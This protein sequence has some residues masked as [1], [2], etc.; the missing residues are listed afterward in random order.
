[1]RDTELYQHLLGLLTP[2]T[3]N[4]VELKPNEQRVDVWTEHAEG[5]K[6][7]C[8]VLGVEL[9]GCDH[10]PE[11]SGRPLDSCQFTTY[12]RAVTLSAEQREQVEADIRD[13]YHRSR[14]WAEK[15]WRRRYLRATRS[16]LEPVI[17]AALTVHRHIGNLLTQFKHRITSAVSEE[18]DSK[19]QMIKKRAYGFHDPESFK[20]AVHLHL[21]GLGLY[22]ASVD[23]SATH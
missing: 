5:T 21:G 7:P 1:M 14:S 9:P 4:R 16:R 6:W 12:L 8:P 10:A 2:W 17:T 11:R 19:I 18:L 15:H 13:P 3:V 22:P 23:A 20:T